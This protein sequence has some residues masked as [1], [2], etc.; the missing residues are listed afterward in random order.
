MI[1]FP[2]EVLCCLRNYRLIYGHE[3]PIDTTQYSHKN[4]SEP[5]QSDFCCRS[6]VQPKQKF[7]L[8]MRQKNAAENVVVDSQYV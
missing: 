2:K 3:K 4:I 6:K 5:K 1:I 7:T 8:I